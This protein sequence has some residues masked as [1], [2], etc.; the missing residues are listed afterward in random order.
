MKCAENTLDEVDV[1]N[2][3]RGIGFDSH[4]EAI[5]PAET[6]GQVLEFSS[7]SVG[8]RHTASLFVFRFGD[9]DV[10]QLDDAPFEAR[11]EGGV[12]GLTW[13]A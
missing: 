6:N 2:L 12:R 8:G 5:D 13:T 4:D 7:S 11:G 10:A 3:R 1:V 9:F